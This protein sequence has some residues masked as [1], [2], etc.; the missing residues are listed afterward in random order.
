M[1]KAAAKS[2]DGK[3]VLLIGLSHANLDR[4]RAD[5]LNGGI[6]IEATDDWP[7]TI[8][9]TAGTTER[10]IAD[11]MIGADLIGPETKVTIDPKL[12]S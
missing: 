11:A 10:E 12:K 2:A 7:V 6:R 5:G 9:I 8:F 4:L 1:I 3:D